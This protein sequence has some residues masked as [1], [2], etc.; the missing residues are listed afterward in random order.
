MSSRPTSPRPRRS[1]ES[2]G[3]ARYLDVTDPRQVT[4]LDGGEQDYP[5]IYHLAAILSG[6]GE[7][8]PT[9][10][11]G[12]EYERLSTTSWRPPGPGRSKQVI[13]PSS[14]AAFG[15]DTPKE[16]TPIDTILRPTTMY[17]ITKVAGRTTQRV[18]QPEI[19][20]G[21]PEPAVSRHR[22][23]RNRA[24]RRHNR[25]RG[26]HVRQSGGRRVHPTPASSPRTPPC[27]S[28]ICPTPWTP[29][30]NLADAEESGN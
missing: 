12:R 14:I 22:L 27:P 26:G 25:L 7:L 15:P 21:R 30:W 11:L 10:V 9:E 20:R 17:G 18:L 13:T 8:N 6:N 28:S 19:R 2:G 5:H 24:R 1:L 29:C 23:P 16:H 3:P 4:A